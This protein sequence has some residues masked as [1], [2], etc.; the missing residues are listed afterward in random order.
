MSDYFRATT[1]I[2]ISN[3]SKFFEISYWQFISVVCLDC[4]S[5]TSKEVCRDSP[6]TNCTSEKNYCISIAIG[7][8]YF[9]GCYDNTEDCKLFLEDEGAICITCDSDNCNDQELEWWFQKISD[10]CSLKCFIF[11]F[12]IF[13][14]WLPW[15]LF[16][17]MGLE[18]WKFNLLFAKNNNNL[19]L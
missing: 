4:L 7:G 10:S 11:S 13:G 12:F 1:T 17:F 6:S 8:T 16:N 15:Y 5:C 14:I 2:G 3:T 18:Y 19:Q 9:R